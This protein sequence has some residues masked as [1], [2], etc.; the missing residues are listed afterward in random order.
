[1]DAMGSLTFSRVGLPI[2]SGGGW[3][4]QRVASNFL[5]NQFL[6]FDMYNKR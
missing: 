2:C 1:M 5:Q 3:K 4:A 6:F